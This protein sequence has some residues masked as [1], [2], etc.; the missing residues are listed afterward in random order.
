MT[1]IAGIPNLSRNAY[2]WLLTI[3]YI[4]YIVFEWFA[5]MWKLIPPHI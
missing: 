3:F 2:N 1:K 5:L 4:S